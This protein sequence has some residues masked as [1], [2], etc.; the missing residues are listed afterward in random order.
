MLEGSCSDYWD[1]VL[2]ASSLS[3]VDNVDEEIGRV[4]LVV[5]LA[6]GSP[7][8]YGV[9]ATADA[10]VPPIEPLEPREAG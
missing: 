3:S 1:D 8:H 9:K 4:A 10:V 2:P 5:L 7:G 6:G